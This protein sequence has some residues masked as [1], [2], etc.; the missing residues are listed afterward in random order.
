MT[1]KKPNVTLL[2]VSLR[3]VFAEDNFLVPASLRAV[4]RLSS[5]FRPGVLL[6][7]T[8]SIKLPRLAVAAEAPRAELEGRTQPPVVPSLEPE[9]QGP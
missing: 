8:C 2:T 3:L 4:T 5:H 6:W 1:A 7:L 9:G